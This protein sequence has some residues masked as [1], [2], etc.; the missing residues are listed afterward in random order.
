MGDEK[1]GSASYKHQTTC[2]SYYVPFVQ[3]SLDKAHTN[4]RLIRILRSKS[5]DVKS[6]LFRNTLFITKS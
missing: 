5:C 1:T 4:Q 3:I 2:K 6:S